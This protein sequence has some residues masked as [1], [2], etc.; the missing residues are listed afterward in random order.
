VLAGFK[1]QKTFEAAIATPQGPRDIAWAIST[2]WSCGLGI[3]TGV[4][5][6]VMLFFGAWTSWTT[7][8]AWPAA[9][10]TGIAFG[11]PMAAWTGDA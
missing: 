7:V 4:F 1:W 2:G 10:L 8:L 11:M 3:V 5:L 9:V 6:I